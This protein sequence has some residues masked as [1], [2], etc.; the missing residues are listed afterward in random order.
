MVTGLPNNSFTKATQ[1]LITVVTTKH[2]K[3]TKWL[4]G[5][6]DPC[7][8]QNPASDESSNDA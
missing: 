8:R 1:E 3:G 5:T 2:K 4:A 7:V 6:V